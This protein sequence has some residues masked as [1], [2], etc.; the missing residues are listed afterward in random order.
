MLRQSPPAAVAMAMGYAVVGRNNRGGVESLR[1]IET[2]RVQPVVD[3]RGRLFYR[4]AA[5]FSLR[6]RERMFRPAM[7]YTYGSAPRARSPAT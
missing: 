4:V 7:S 1:W 5:D 2:L 3:D 6:E